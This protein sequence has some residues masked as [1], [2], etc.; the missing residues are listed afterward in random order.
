MTYIVEPGDLVLFRIG[1]DIAFK[2]DTV[3]FF[4]VFRV[5]SVS[6]VEGYLWRICNKE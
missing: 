3:A 2:V 6:Q 4:D 1:T 5:Q